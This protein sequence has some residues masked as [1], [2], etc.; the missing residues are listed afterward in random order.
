MLF[1]NVIISVIFSGFSIITFNWNGNFWIQI[2]S[3]E[4]SIVQIY[5]ILLYFKFNFSFIKISCLDEKWTIL[6][7]FLAVVFEILSKFRDFVKYGDHIEK[8]THKNLSDYNQFLLKKRFEFKKKNYL[9][10]KREIQVIVF[11]I[12][13]TRSSERISF[14]LIR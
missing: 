10:K 7:Y 2:V 3:S 11:M 5:Y 8:K 6:G 4:R 13:I 12:N 9:V 1:G 14:N